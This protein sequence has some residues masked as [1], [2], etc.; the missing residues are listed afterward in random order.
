MV[1][2]KKFNIDGIDYTR[3][4]TS[5]NFDLITFRRFSFD[6]KPQMV[7][8]LFSIQKIFFVKTTAGWG[9]YRLN[10]H[11]HIMD[12]SGFHDMGPKMEADADPR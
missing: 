9:N 8:S 6:I 5:T 1:K 11:T 10:V 7:L 2:R 4:T 3:T 12:L